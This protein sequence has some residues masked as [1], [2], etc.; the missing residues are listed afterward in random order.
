MNLLPIKGLESVMNDYSQFSSL[1]DSSPRTSATPYLFRSENMRF[2]QRRFQMKGRVLM[3]QSVSLL[4]A[5]ISEKSER[6]GKS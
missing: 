5:S 6:K 1:I 2:F 3:L 4:S